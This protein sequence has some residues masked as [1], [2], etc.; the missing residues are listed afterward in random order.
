MVI[1]VQNHK[2]LISKTQYAGKN[3]NKLNAIKRRFL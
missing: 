3:V 1:Y 2:M